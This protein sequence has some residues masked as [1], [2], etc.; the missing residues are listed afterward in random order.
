[1]LAFGGRKKRIMSTF[2]ELISGG[3]ADRVDEHI[4]RYSRSVYVV[5]PFALRITL[6]LYPR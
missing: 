4:Q 3:E 2:V 5:N 6:Q 1:M